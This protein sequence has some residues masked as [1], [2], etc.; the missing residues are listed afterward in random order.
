MEESTPPPELEELSTLESTPLSVVEPS[1]PPL[2]LLSTLES[3]W[4]PSG[5]THA[6]A[7]LVCAQV[8]TAALADEQ[9]PWSSWLWQ[10]LTV[11]PAAQTQLTKAAHGVSAAAI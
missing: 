11:P 1:P 5:K 10:P 8:V 7:Q 9:D 2:L 6:L 3:P 4:P